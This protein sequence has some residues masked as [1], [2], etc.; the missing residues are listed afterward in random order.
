MEGFSSTYTPGMS[1][2]P[3]YSINDNIGAGGT[4]V[5]LRHGQ[6]SKAQ[7]LKSLTI[8]DSTGLSPEMSIY[9]LK[10]A[11]GTYVDN[12]AFAW[13]GTDASKVADVIPIKDTDWIINGGKGHVVLSKIDH[14]ITP[15]GRSIGIHIV[16]ESPFNAG[17]TSDLSLT[18]GF[19]E[20]QI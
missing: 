8:Y 17:A 12:D 19:Q 3:D 10:V 1:A 14:V 9:L 5:E 7:L 20:T 2:T 16:C 15:E 18:F 4:L 13:V 6:S 11:P